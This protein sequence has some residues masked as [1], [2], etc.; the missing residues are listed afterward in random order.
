ML[1]DGGVG[2]FLVDVGQFL[3]SD[4]G[5]PLDQDSVNFVIKIAQLLP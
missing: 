2:Y 1:H 3:E 5:R 4:F